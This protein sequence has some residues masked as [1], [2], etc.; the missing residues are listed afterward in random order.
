MN[1]IQAEKKLK[2][3]KRAIEK[4]NISYGEIIELQNLKEYI[5]DDVVLMEWAGMPEQTAKQ[6]VFIYSL[7]G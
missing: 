6:I 1:K 4:E 5:K 7:K 3:I 2:E